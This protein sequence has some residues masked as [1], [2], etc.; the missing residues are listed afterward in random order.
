MRPIQRGGMSPAPVIVAAA[1]AVFGALTPFPAQAQ[2]STKLDTTQFVVV[3]E[4]I[5]AG[6]ADFALREIYQDLNFGSQM[7]RQM[8][9]AFPQPL[10][11]QGGIGAAPGFPVLPPRLPAEPASRDRFER[12]RPACRAVSVRALSIRC[13]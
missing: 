12:D 1:L 13:A 10:F 4:G 2:T 6:M 5:A 3:G 8:K 7:A 11:Q 9:T